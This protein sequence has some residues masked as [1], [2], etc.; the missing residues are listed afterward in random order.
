[1]HGVTNWRCRRHLTLV[2]PRVPSLWVLDF[3]GPVFRGG[4][5]RRHE[6]LVRRVGIDAN[7]EQVNVPM[8]HPR[9]L[10]QTEHTRTHKSY[11]HAKLMPLEAV[12]EHPLHNAIRCGLY[13]LEGDY[14]LARRN[15]CRDDKISPHPY[16]FYL[17]SAHVKFPPIIFSI[18]IQLWVQCSEAILFSLKCFFFLFSI[19]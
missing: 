13:C 4:E 2:N 5:M 19:I 1:M 3:E 6:S 15:T 10:P 7:G 12:R 17:L 14:W 9:D 16:V 8:P 11:H 18:F